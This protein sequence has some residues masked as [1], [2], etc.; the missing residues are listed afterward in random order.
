MVVL[1]GLVDCY[2]LPNAWSFHC[3]SIE[4]S[5][6][7][8]MRLQ[9]LLKMANRNAIVQTV[10]AV[11]KGSDGSIT[12]SMRESPSKNEWTAQM[13]FLSW[14]LKFPNQSANVDTVAA[15][16]KDVGDGCW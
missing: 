7:A 13:E 2:L 16:R 1:L 15:G 6:T 14:F 4:N 3:Y 5:E 10:A 9:W 8:R 11:C 12:V